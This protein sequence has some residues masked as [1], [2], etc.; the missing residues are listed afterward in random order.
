[1]NAFNFNLDFMKKFLTLV[2]LVLAAAPSARAWTYNDA[3]ALLIF[4]ESGFND[5]EFDLGNVSQFTSVA[6]GSTITVTGWDLSLV[7]NTFGSDLTGVSVIVAGTTS[8]YATSRA[9]WL[10][11]GDPTV[12]PSD[13]TPSGWQSYLWSIINSV[14]TR[15]LIYRVP[16]SGSTAYS[17]DPAGVYGLAS[18]DDIVSP[19]GNSIAQLGG[20]AA[21]TVEGVAPATFGFWQIHPSTA[22]PKPTATFLGNFT[23]TAAGALTFTAGTVA[24]P[25]NTIVSIARSGGV[26]TVT[27]TTSPGG[28]YWLTS[29]NVVSSPAASW[30]TVSG[31]VGGDGNNQS[32]ADTNSAPSAFYRVVR[33]P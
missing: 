29:A 11:S 20:N 6:S 25:P 24:A 1:M 28:N 27:F 32:L 30:P 15:P 7:T 14:G 4:R 2:A 33:T 16:V 13:L 8:R 9:A 18:Y 23:I 26:S 19:S 10:T 22:Y 17:I 31:P 3:D 12:V 21:F 5:V